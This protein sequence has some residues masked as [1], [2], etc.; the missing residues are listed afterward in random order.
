MTKDLPEETSDFAEE[1]TQAHRLAELKLLGTPAFS[2][3]A[4]TA[5]RRTEAETEEFKA[6]W[7]EAPEEMQ[8]AACVYS[9]TIRDLIGE[10]KPSYFMVEHPVD[11]SGITGEPGSHGTVD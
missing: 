1:G 3:T 4:V 8:A 5:R 6:L 10:E 9:N 11:V 7:D 2:G